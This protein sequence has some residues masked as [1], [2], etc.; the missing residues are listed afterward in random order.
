M[1]DVNPL[2]G[3]QINQLSVLWK[4]KAHRRLAWG[5]LGQA[6]HLGSTSHVVGQKTVPTMSE[7]LSLGE[8]PASAISGD[9]VRY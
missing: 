2:I 5:A 9:K 1:T 4:G 6:D 3:P 7:V 8:A